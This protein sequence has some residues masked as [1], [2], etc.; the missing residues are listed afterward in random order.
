MVNSPLSDPGLLISC[1]DDCLIDSSDTRAVGLERSVTKSRPS[2]AD[3]D[4]GNK[5]LHTHHHGHKVHVF[6]AIC[7]IG[8]L[9]GKPG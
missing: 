1:S 5:A 7:P 9:Y 2:S 8:M 3:V 4:V 6:L